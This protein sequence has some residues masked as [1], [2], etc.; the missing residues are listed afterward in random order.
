MNYL[1]PKMLKRMRNSSYVSNELKYF[2]F[3]VINKI[4]CTYVTVLLEYI[5]L[6]TTMYYISVRNLMPTS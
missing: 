2:G 6:S 1:G 4:L 5:C 3:H